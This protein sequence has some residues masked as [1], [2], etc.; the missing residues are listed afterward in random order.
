MEIIKSGGGR[1]WLFENQYNVSYFSRTSQEKNRSENF[2]LIL[3][4]NTGIEPVTR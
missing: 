1:G 2:K 4:G 3:M